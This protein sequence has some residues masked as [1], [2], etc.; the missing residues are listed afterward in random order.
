VITKT[1]DRCGD[2]INTDS[3]MNTVLPSFSISKMDNFLMG[4]RSVDLCPKCEKKL[5][6]WLDRKED[7]QDERR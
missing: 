3:M 5:K 1:C 2:K 6:E 7:E 4:W